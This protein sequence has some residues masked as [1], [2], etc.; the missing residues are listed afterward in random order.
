MAHK[1]LAAS[2]PSKGPSAEQ[3][4]S[5]R[6]ISNLSMDERGIASDADRTSYCSASKQRSIPKA[7]VR[8]I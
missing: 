1:L 2:Q 3:E 4:R 5:I 8:N 6:V 7:A